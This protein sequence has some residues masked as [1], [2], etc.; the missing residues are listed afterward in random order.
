MIKVAATN[1][2]CRVCDMAIQ[3][4]GAAGVGPD[5]GIAYAYAQARAL[6]FADGPD[7]VHRRQIARLELKGHLNA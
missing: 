3:A 5:S 2:A 1:M 6:R 4:H 7:E